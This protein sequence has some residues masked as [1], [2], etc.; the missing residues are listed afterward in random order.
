MKRVTIL[1]DD[2]GIYRQ[3]KA[4]AAKEGRPVKD[5]VAEVLADWLRRRPRVP[6]EITA[7]RR[8]ALQRSKELLERMPVREGLILETLDEIREGRMQ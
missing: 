1:F 4:E 2:E 6:P 8:D 5:V 3:M 7:R